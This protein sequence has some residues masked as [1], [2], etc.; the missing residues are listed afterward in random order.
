MKRI[1]VIA[2]S[3]L[4]A[5]WLIGMQFQ[6]AGADRE[7]LAALFALPGALWPLAMPLFGVAVLGFVTA[8]RFNRIYPVMNAA[9]ITK[10]NRI[11]IA[12]VL[13]GPTLAVM[14]QI[15]FGLEYFSLI[16]K[17]GMMRGL[18]IFQSL[19]FIVIGNYVAIQDPKNGAIFRTPWTV[20]SIAVC[21]VVHRY[22][23]NGIV[24][25]SIITL[26]G[27]AFLPGKL[28]IFTHVATLLTLKIAALIYSM[29]L[30]RRLE[31]QGLAMRE[32][33]TDV[34]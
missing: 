14:M 1:Y 7:P 30:W 2:L 25:I 10:E 8:F 33:P 24:L 17:D 26:I 27:A 21:A 11:L 18:A 19:T 28:V 15:Y 9:R 29:R 5:A 20:K 34:R 16:D 4:L 32:S 3:L 22:L 12:G 31:A 13:F 23:G 6:I